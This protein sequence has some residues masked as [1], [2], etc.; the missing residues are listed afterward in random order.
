MGIINHPAFPPAAAALIAAR[1]LDKHSPGEIGEAIEILIDVL[2]LMGGDLDAE[3][4]NDLEDDFTLSPMAVAYG[5]DGA[6]C[7]VSDQDAGA[8]VEWHTM[9]GSQKHGPN[10]L[11][12]HEDYEDD[13]PAEQDDH[14]GQ[15]DED[16]INT[17]L[18]TV[19]YT[20]GASG[21]GCPI[22]DEGGGNVEDEAQMWFAPAYDC[23]QAA[24]PA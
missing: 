2:D 24:F 20:T 19:R 23:P 16:G 7:A 22:S 4:G 9:R 8:Y 3:N 11:A 1:L 12:G 18:D 13:D 6:G 14:E 10:L 21:P 15:C 5:S 17:A